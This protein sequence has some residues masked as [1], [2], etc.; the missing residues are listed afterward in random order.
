MRQHRS[1]A[2]LLA[3]AA[4]LAACCAVAP[5]AAQ[6]SPPGI[7]SAIPL[8]SLFT[9]A[10]G[11]VLANATAAGGLGGPAL[12]PAIAG[13]FAGGLTDASQN[14]AQLA[15]NLQGQ[16]ALYIVCDL[17]TV[18]DAYTHIVNTATNPLAALG[19]G[20]GL[21][22]NL[23]LASTTSGPLV[24]LVTTGLSSQCQNLDP[25]YGELAPV[26][27]RLLGNSTSL[28]QQLE[29]LAAL[30]DRSQAQAATTSS[31]GSKLGSGLSSLLQNTLIGS[32]TKSLTGGTASGSGSGSSTGHAG[33][34]SL[35][36]PFMQSFY[37]SLFSA[38]GAS[39]TA[40]A[41]TARPTAAAT[42]TSSTV[43][44]TSS[45]AGRVGL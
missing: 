21:F 39:P 1:M 6:T 28:A 43:A 25:N 36:G 45:S 38:A 33:V 44:P 4:A 12:L 41:T 8:F 2:S 31:S 29:A 24:G 27:T 22:S 30:Y 15:N 20:S 18:Y 37:S 19:G 3:F 13:N 32:I 26:I 10:A 17:L 16:N 14:L 5:A 23:G 11:P 9:A 35:A 7:Q 34:S 42:V 40:A